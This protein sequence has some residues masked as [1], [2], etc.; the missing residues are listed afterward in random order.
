[1]GPKAVIERARQS[2]NFANADAIRG[3]ERRPSF[4]LGPR[5]Q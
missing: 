2:V 5:K 1:M 4:G 3:S